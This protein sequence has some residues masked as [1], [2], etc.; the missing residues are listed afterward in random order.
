MPC[1]A[2]FSQKWV[3]RD[4]LKSEDNK[5]VYIDIVKVHFD[6]VYYLDNPT[7]KVTVKPIDNPAL[8]TS[9]EVISKKSF[10]NNGKEID[11]SKPLNVGT[12]RVEVNEWSTVCVSDL[13]I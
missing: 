6:P 7:E 11:V 1:I 12:Y 9:Y 5:N 3:F 10:D 8:G 4:A 13:Y 2:V